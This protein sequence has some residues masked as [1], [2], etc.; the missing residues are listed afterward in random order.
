[1]SN[2]QLKV[3]NK[4]ACLYADITEALL[5]PLRKSN[6]VSLRDGTKEIHF[7]TGQK[8]IHTA[9]YK[10]REYPDGTVKTVYADGRQE[11]RY[12]TGRLRIKD[13]DGNIVMDN[14]L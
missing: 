9:E 5:S 2:A 3:H 6:C 14:R 8:E 7:N 11:T 1:M 4:K 10:R 13:K 12:P